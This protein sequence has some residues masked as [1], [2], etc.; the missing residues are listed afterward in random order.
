MNVT[1]FLDIIKNQ[2]DER[3]RDAENAREE[4]EADL[5]NLR[6]LINQSLL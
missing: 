4:R 6:K 3:R 2:E 1:D 5:E